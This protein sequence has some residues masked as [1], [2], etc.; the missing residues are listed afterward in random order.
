MSPDPPHCFRADY[1][2]STAGSLVVLRLELK[3][4]LIGPTA[5]HPLKF[6]VDTGAD[7][8]IIPEHVAVS[9]GLRLG[10][11]SVGSV[12]AATGGPM[13]T[14][15]A[16]G[17][18]YSFDKLPGPRFKSEFAVSP[19]LKTDFGLLAWRD[20]AL[21]FD[22]RTVILP[23]LMTSG[24]TVTGRPGT[25]RFCLRSDRDADRIG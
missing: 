24:T 23:N 8:S 9:I 14:R 25:I 20:L 10:G 15:L 6:R 11:W 7:I 21:D 22:I 17:V 5:D 12:R 3:L 19:D 1:L 4:R 18:R 16:R 2:A 13:R